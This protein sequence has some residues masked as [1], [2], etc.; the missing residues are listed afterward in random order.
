MNQT[1]RA[2]LEFKSKWLGP[3]G[4]TGLIY[5][6]IYGFN[7]TLKAALELSNTNSMV[8]NGPCNWR[9]HQH[10]SLNP[11]DR[12]SLWAEQL[13]WMGT[14]RFYWFIHGDKEGVN[15]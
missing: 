9:L 6:F 2:A 12:F 3:Y 5:E 7:V 8:H 1:V 15:S 10:L 11:G 4:R 13:R 14:F